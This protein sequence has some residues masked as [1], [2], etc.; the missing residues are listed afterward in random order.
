MAIRCLAIAAECLNVRREQEEVL[1]MF[2]KIQHETGWRVDFLRPE[3]K[4]KW[5]WDVEE[6][7][8]QPPQQQQMPPAVMST[9]PMY[10]FYQQQATSLPP[11]PTIPPVPAIPRGIV[12]PL[13]RTAD[14]NAPTHP[15]QNYYVA[16]SQHHHNNHYLY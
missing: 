3:L 10:D 2:E 11:A 6:N 12:N 4:K 13:M 9:P 14:F 1:T 15:Y 16:P 8:P 5:G 7:Y